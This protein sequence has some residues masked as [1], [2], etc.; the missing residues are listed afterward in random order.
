MNDFQKY[1]SSLNV[2][3]WTELTHKQVCRACALWIAENRHDFENAIWQ[4]EPQ[5]ALADAVM[6]SFDC[7]GRVD[8][9]GVKVANADIATLIKQAVIEQAQISAESWLKMRR[10]WLFELGARKLNPMENLI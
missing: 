4:I 8:V 6:A 2:N 9:E 5:E 7:L 10:G 1:L 3:A